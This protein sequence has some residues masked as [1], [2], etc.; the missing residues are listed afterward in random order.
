MVCH[1]FHQCTQVVCFLFAPTSVA[2]GA[3]CDILNCITQASRNVSPLHL[4][5]YQVVATPFAEDHPTPI[6]YQ[7][8]VSFP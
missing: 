8:I 4:I 1:S 6:E 3:D 5:P 7:Y 2:Q